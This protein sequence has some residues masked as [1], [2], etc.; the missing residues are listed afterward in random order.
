MINRLAIIELDYHVECLNTL[1][2]VFASADFEIKIFTKIEIA[3][4]IR[5][6][7]NY[8]NYRWHV[9][10]KGENVNKFINRNFDQINKCDIIF[11]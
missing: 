2:K 8:D 5:N 6:S 7:C 1:C 4:E 11:I 10:E 9:P 3:S